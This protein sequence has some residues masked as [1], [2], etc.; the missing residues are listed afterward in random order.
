MR[1][2]IQKTYMAWPLFG[3]DASRFCL[4]DDEISLTGA[5]DDGDRMRP[6]RH[7][8]CTIECRRCEGG[9]QV[10]LFVGDANQNIVVFYSYRVCLNILSRRAAQYL[11]GTYI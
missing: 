6:F 11:A 7:L 3:L 8:N 5:S 2:M 4:E 1:N 9:S 10:M